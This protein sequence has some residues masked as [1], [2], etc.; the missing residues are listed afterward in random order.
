M[1]SSQRPLQIQ[2]WTP[3][4]EIFD[5]MLTE[6]FMVTDN[7][8]QTFRVLGFWGWCVGAFQMRISESNHCLGDYVKCDMLLYLTGKPLILPILCVYRRNSCLS[9]NALVGTATCF[10]FHGAHLGL[11]A[12]G[13]DHSDNPLFSRPHPSCFWLWSNIPDW[14]PWLTRIILY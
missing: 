4:S 14:H 13:M 12:P 11:T 1:L 9:S 10:Q 8:Y 3:K 5:S 2:H 6:E 7:G